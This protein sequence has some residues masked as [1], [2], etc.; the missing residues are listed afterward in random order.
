VKYY[1]LGDRIPDITNQEQRNYMAK[2]TVG[3]GASGMGIEFR[4]PKKGEWYLSGAIPVA[5]CA[6]NDFTTAYHIMKIVK[7]KRYEV[8]EEV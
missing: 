8:I 3:A 1:L 7:I 6:P 4:C 5:Y 2:F